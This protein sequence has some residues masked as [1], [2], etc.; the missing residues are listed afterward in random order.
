MIF[1]KLFPVALLISKARQLLACLAKCG[2]VAF[3]FHLNFLLVAFPVALFA[4][5]SQNS[6]AGNTL[7]VTLSATNVT[8]YGMNNGTIV[9]SVSGVSGGN[10]NF[11]LNPGSAT[12]NTGLF[13]DLPAGVYSVLADD[14]AD[15]GTS[16]VTITEPPVSSLPSISLAS[17]STICPGTESASISYLSVSGSPVSYSISVGTPALT[18]FVPILDTPFVVSPLTLSLPSGISKGN[19]QFILSLKNASGCASLPQNFILNFDDT[20]SPSFNSFPEDKTIE[21]GS[22]SSPL[23]TGSPTASDNCGPVT[24]SHSDAAVQDNCPSRSTVKRMWKATDKNGNFISKI[25]EIHIIDDIPPTLNCTSITVNDAS[26]IPAADLNTGISALDNCGISTIELVDEKYFGLDM[27]AGFCPNRVERIYRAVDQCGNVSTQ[28]KQVITVQNVGT[29][30]VCQDDVPFIPVIFSKP[31]EKFV[32]Q[33]IARNGICCNV[34]G[35][36]PPRC[37][38]FN[39]YLHK[40][41]VGLIFKIESGAKPPG[42]LYYQI[43]CGPQHQVGDVLCLQ[44]GRFYTITFCKPGNSENVYSIQSISGITSTEGL[45]TR[46]DNKCTGQISVTGIEPSTVSWSVKSPNDQ[47]LLRYLS[48]LNCLNPTFTPDSIAP[49]SVE[50]QVCGS[51]IGTAV[52]NGNPIVDC[53]EVTVTVLPAIKIAFDVD[54]MNICANNIPTMH[55]NISPVNLNYSYKWYKGANASGTLL[56]SDPFWTPSEEGSF[57]LVA[58]ETQ[59]G[60][61]CNSATNNF[62][63]SFDKSGPMVV[64][65]PDN[66][67]IECND[68]TAETKIATWLETAK[69]SDS[70]VSG[71]AVKNDYSP[72]V[73]ACGLEKAVKFWATDGCGNISEV[74]AFI[75]IVDTKAPNVSKS[76]T[77]G[78]SAC[79]GIDPNSNSG[80]LAWLSNHGNSVITDDCASTLIWTDNHT[81]QLWSGTACNNTISVTFTASDDCGNKSSTQATYTIADIIPPVFTFCPPDVN[82]T[83]D[84]D[85]CYATGVTLGLATATDNCVLKSITNNAPAQFPNG[86]T[87]VTWTATDACDNVS[88]CTQRVSVTDPFKPTISC[89]SDVT[90]TALPGNCFL[91]NVVVPDPTIADNCAIM[92]QTWVMSGA[93][94]GNSPAT[95][96]NSVSGATFNVGMTTVTYT[97]KDAAGNSEFCSFNVWIKD[98]VKPVLTSGCPAD[99]TQS[100]DP[101]QCSAVVIVPQPVV[102]DPCNEGYTVINSFNGT[103]N[104]SGTFPAGVTI[105]VWTITDISG[106]SISCTQKV[107][108]NNANT[109]SISCPAD[110]TQIALP[111]NCALSNVIVPDPIVTGICPIVSQTWLMT[112]ATVGTSNGTGLNSVSGQTFNVGV[113]NVTYTVTDAT[114]KSATCS[115]NVWIKDLVKPVL[116]SGCP[117]DIFVSTDPGQCSAM[118]TVPKPNVNDPCNEGFTITNSFNNSDNASGTYPVGTTIVVWTIT[119]ASGNNTVCSQNVT[120]NDR[121]PTLSC[122][123]NVTVMADFEKEFASNVATTPP[124]FGDDCPGLILS[125]KMTGVSTGSSALTGVNIFPSPFTFNQGVTNIEYTLT[126]INGHSVTCS[127]VVTVLS[128]PEIDCQ[129]DLTIDSKPGFCN[130]LIDTGFPIKISGAE[131]ISYNWTM[132]GATTGLGMGAITPIPFTFNVGVTTIVWTATNISGSDVCTQKVTVSDKEPPVLVA[133]APFSFCVE[134]LISASIVSSLLQLNPTPDCYLFKKG[135]LVLDV[136]PTNISDNCTPGDQLVLHWK[137]D[138]SDP[139]TNPSISGTGQL[140]TYGSDIIFPGDGSSF[141]DVVHTIT[142]WVVDQSGNESVHMPVSITIHPRPAVSLNNRI[143]D[144]EFI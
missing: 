108:V 35:P 81:S 53:N 12:N 73:H 61:I 144:F 49:P 67:V 88:T 10:V 122:P 42:S 3:R 85:K 137:I 135:S 87:T 134:N 143:S 56:S 95:G 64:A 106:N 2:N 44:G 17:L 103:S 58:T 32:S 18:G 116:T 93:T 130:T 104:A 41:A 115:F 26:K 9:S 75:R 71:I 38:A 63:I 50:Y 59:S 1:V 117:P 127:F 140:S 70:N 23:A 92:S 96:I 139:T 136:I 45:V 57:S 91:A 141:K 62:S 132:S 31:D 109:L 112:G 13:T 54:P 100:T 138:Y 36:P 47:S 34:T 51:L 102:T 98:L 113:T 124:V 5:V 14:G 52:C 131:P 80:F 22:D 68:Q 20:T 126:D 107:T 8:C 65:P 79:D 86:V 37:I 46:A 101:N 7:T 105:V 11:T 19:Y 83:D 39:V 82:V 24:L 120:V 4:T 21:C 89:P 72:F 125:W 6:R 55:A 40:D 121:I 60:V 77:N 111:G 129:L 123:A 15:T 128:K 69:A 99:V 48:C 28:C 90:Q 43:D 30:K 119:D 97:V 133:P 16:T 33:S 66:L 118:V 94:I 84:A 25:Q 110:V 29:C 76:A 142:Y 27:T 74:M 78:S 114:G